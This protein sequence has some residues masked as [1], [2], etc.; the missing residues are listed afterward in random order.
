M[1]DLYATEE[2]SRELLVPDTRT[3]MQK[4][5]AKLDDERWLNEQGAEA[6]AEPEHEPVALPE[7]CGTSYCSCIECLKE[8]P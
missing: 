5:K 6:L 4:A 8:K 1:T 3:P 2:E 7:N